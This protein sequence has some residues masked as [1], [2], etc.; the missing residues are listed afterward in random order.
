M[1]QL[2]LYSLVLLLATFSLGVAVCPSTTG[3][4]DLHVHEPGGGS[5]DFKGLCNTWFN[6]FQV[7]GLSLNAFFSCSTFGLAP[8]DPRS[9]DV[10]AV[11]GSHMTK[12]AVV[13]KTMMNGKEA[14]FQ[15]SYHDNLKVRVLATVDGAILLDTF[16]TE[17]LGPLKTDDVTIQMSKSSLS[18]ANSEWKFVITPGTFRLVSGERRT[19]FDVAVAGLTDSHDLACAAHGVIG[20]GFDGLHIEGK[21]DDYVPGVDGTFVTSA[22][23]EGSVEGDV[24]DYI[25]DGP[26]AINFTYA[27]FYDLMAPPRDTT[28]LNVVPALGG[29]DGSLSMEGKTAAAGGA[30]RRLDDCEKAPTV[31]PTAAPSSS[32]APSSAPS[33]SPSSSPT[34]E[35]HPN[36]VQCGSC[37]PVLL[38]HKL[39]T[40]MTKKMVVMDTTSTLAV[41]VP[42]AVNGTC[43]QAV[44][45][46]R[47]LDINETWMN[48]IHPVLGDRKNMTNL[49]DL[50]AAA[51]S[52]DSTCLGFNWYRDEAK[53]EED[54]YQYV[55]VE[56][57]SSTVVVGAKTWADDNG[58]QPKNV[59]FFK[60]P[61]LRS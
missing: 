35:A 6:M 25:V 37:T 48:D 31:A 38:D 41:A 45:T 8:E 42:F 57:K 26:F 30:G 46:L 59:R 13:A 56:F 14:L 21:K 5:F 3:T 55:H 43:G 10:F 23:G 19:R 32:L 53:E 11:E 60:K 15:V 61:T 20:Q 4:G 49:K 40:Q 39:Y 54:E 12:M 47:K 58:Y 33:S 34:C 2:K 7:Q 36:D 9:K 28:L 24:T 51:C 44:S 16:I 1:G 18:V 50:A 22:Q 52:A 17:E 29:T 27:R